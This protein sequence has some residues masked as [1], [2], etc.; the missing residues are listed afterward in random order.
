M[1]LTM[2][3]KSLCIFIYKSI[4][5]RSNKEQITLKIHI[6]YLKYISDIVIIITIVKSL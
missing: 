3:N 1:S 5:I 6:N 2:V 4:L